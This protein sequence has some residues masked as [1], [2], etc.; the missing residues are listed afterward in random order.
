MA[1]TIVTSIQDD[2]GYYNNLA[3]LR[4]GLQVAD[5]EAR[6]H[7][8]GNVNNHTP[9]IV[10]DGKVR[11]YDFTRSAQCR[12][13]KDMTAHLGG[14]LPGLQEA[15]LEQI[16]GAFDC[17]FNYYSYKGFFDQVGRQRTESMKMLIFNEAQKYVAH[18]YFNATSRRTG[19][20]QFTVTASLTCQRYTYFPFE[21][22][23]FE[24]V[25]QALQNM[26][27]REWS[28]IPRRFQITHEK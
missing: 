8:R 7:F 6:I 16:R 15:D 13:R 23:N 3:F 10:F 17:L 18:V 28:S 2:F 5:E 14:V 1:I 25:L 9:E 19:P 4:R 26:H 24:A 12:I 20:R 22:T 21:D 27:V 11:V